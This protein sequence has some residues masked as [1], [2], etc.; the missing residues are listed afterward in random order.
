[1]G[2]CLR[3]LAALSVVGLAFGALTGDATA[4]ERRQLGQYVVN[5]GFETEPAYLEQFNAA[6]IAVFRSDGQ[7]AFGVEKTLKVEVT[8][9]G[10][11]R[12]FDLTPIPGR[13]GAYHAPFFPTRTGGYIFRFFG[14]I[15]NQ[16][17]NER[18]ESGPARFDDVARKRV[19]RSVALLH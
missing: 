15:E 12:T 9:G 19:A 5:V 14:T 18:F 16:E 17:V 10:D 1:M 3:L 2:M 8:K 6:F 13:E 7:P 11:S 4:H